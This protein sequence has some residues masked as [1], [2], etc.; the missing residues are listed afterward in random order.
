MLSQLT[1]RGAPEPLNSCQ[2]FANLQKNEQERSLSA[3]SGLVI[4][5]QLLCVFPLTVTQ[6]TREHYSPR[7]G[8]GLLPRKGEDDRQLGEACT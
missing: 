8:A 1:Q 5:W 3:G 7:D 4:L 2:L 6:R